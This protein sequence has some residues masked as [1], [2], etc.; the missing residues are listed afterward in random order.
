MVIFNLRKFD[1]R[2]FSAHSRKWLFTAAVVLFGCFQN[3]IAQPTDLVI[4]DTT[5]TGTAT[6]SASHSITAGPNVIIASTGNVAFNAGNFIALRPG[7]IVA[8]GGEFSGVTNIVTGIETDPGAPVVVP[9]DFT[10]EQN[11]PNPFNPTTDI[12]YGL[13]AAQQVRI[14]VFNLLG[15][16]VKTL[17]SGRQAAGFHT[18]TWNGTNAT[19]Q[20]VGSGIYVYA[21]ETGGGRVVKKMIL[22]K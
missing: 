7:F 9:V 13:P 15:V 2:I 14:T 1:H 6:F 17:F 20:V 4:T 16:R 10:V 5:L 22:L 3:A 12:R 11:F 19:G 21:V 8:G 18:I